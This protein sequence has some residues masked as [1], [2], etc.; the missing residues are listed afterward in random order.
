MTAVSGPGATE[1]RSRVSDGPRKKTPSKETREK[2]KLEIALASDDDAV[3]KMEPLSVHLRRMSIEVP[4]RD[5][6][7][8]SDDDRSEIPG[9]DSPRKSDVESLRREREHAFKSVASN[10]NI[11]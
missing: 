2:T 6:L 8:G 5:R 3:G 7:A 1:K 9:D 11:P 4:V 10:N